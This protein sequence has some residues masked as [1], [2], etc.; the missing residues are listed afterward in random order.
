M[1]DADGHQPHILSV[2]SNAILMSSRSLILRAAG[3]AVEEAYAVDKAMS[4]VE[5]DSIDVTLICHTI[6]KGDQQ[7]LVAFV[8]DKRKLMPILCIRSYAYEA[9]PRS[10]VAVDNDPEELLKTLK[11]AIAPNRPDPY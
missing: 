4:L 8:R 2:G 11:L 6:P 9:A 1:S 3:Y 7:A 10:C 5:A